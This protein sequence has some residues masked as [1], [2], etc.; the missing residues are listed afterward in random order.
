MNILINIAHPGHVHLFKYAIQLW[1]E[2]GHKI[3][4]VARDKDVTLA[5]LDEYKIPYI[6]GSVRQYSLGKQLLELYTHTAKLVVL[7]RQFQPDVFISVG[8]TFAAW[9]A[10]IVGKPHI[11]FDDTEHAWLEHHLY[12]PFTQLICTPSCFTKD[13]G[14]K[15][16][17]YSGYQEL[18]YL[19]PHYFKPDSKILVELGLAPGEP[20]FIV[21]FVSWKAMHDKGYSGVNEAG[22]IQLVEILKKY[23]KVIIST[24]TKGLPEFLKSEARKIPPAQIHNLLY[25]STMYIGEGG[26]MATEAALL[27]T[28]SIFIN[29]LSGGNWDEL[30]NK[31]HL[32]YACSKADEAIGTIS[33]LL[34]TSHLKDIWQDRRRRM[35]AD[36]I[37]VTAWMVDL[38]ENYPKNKG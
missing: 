15:Q 21:R 22:K 33:E 2:H 38:I 29:P 23:G 13:L 34:S 30:Q 10:F 28:P 32:L 4:I 24:E 27:G 37:D 19:H 1:K 17:R 35:L 8:S 26:T 14:H 12:M 3:L 20:F 7:S 11:A 9:A 31:Y 36:T 25:Y 16:I 5:L 6:V 18:A